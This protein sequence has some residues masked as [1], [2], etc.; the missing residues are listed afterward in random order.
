MDDLMH[1]YTYIWEFDVPAENQREFERIYGPDGQWV[2]LFCR[3]SGFS[4]TLLLQDR[5]TPNRYLTID[6]WRDEA[7]YRKFLDQFADEYA[8]LDLTCEGLAERE[9]SLGSYTEPQA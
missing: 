6:R 1:G 3:A 7:A 2:A 8:A 4:G 9:T 5:T